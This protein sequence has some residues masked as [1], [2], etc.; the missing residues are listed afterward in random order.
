MVDVL[1]IEQRQLNMSR[2]HGR[3]TKPEMQVRRGLHALGLRYRLHV[4]ALPGRPDLVFSK[5]H[6]VIFI[7]GCFWHAHGCSLSKLPATRREFWKKKLEGN[8]ARD[9]RA[10]AA[11]RAQ[12]WRV[13][14]IWE[15]A[16]R[17]VS[18]IGVSEAIRLAKAFIDSAEIVEW[19]IE[20]YAAEN[21][22]QR[23]DDK[24]P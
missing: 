13:L 12:E 4:R 5:H 7:H 8:F 11:L 21:G 23:F 2:I 15:C 18:R 3:D 10:V 1:T 17:G 24:W 22:A 9:K 16:L 14:V 6:A 19:T 20:G